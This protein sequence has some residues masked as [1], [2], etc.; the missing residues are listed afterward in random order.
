M[1]FLRLLR[2][3]SEL[4]LGQ[5]VGIAL[6]AGL[7]N[8][9]V[10]VVISAAADPHARATDTKLLAATFCVVSVAYSLSQR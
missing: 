4:N 10:L 1:E 8:A 5:M 7:S 2:R 3:E 6:V 9:M